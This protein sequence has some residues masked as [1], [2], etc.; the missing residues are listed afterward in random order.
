MQQP[1]VGHRVWTRRQALRTLAG[2]LTVPPIIAALTACGSRTSSVNAGQAGPQPA[3]GGDSTIA[4][5][6]RAAG[7]FFCYVETLT[8]D[9][10]SVYGYL[11]PVGC[12]P[13]GAFGRG[14]R[15][16]FRFMVLDVS[17]GK[18]VTPDEAERVQ[19]RLPFVGELAADY[20]QRGEGRVADAPWTW[21][22][23]WDVPLDYPLGT[24]DYG[25]V[26]TL[27]GGASGDWKPPALVD[28]T[29]GIDTRPQIREQSA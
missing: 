23:C 5:K 28:P 2:A 15:I 21:D 17:T 13:S 3:T 26:I 6:S 1:N 7:P 14:E 29:R 16:V 9:R 11:A 18:Y 10:P 27:K 24:L 25:I 4:L 8:A 12:Q 22:Y 20:K 19:V